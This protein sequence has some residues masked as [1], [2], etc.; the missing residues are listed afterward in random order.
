MSRLINT[1]QPRR[2][3]KTHRNIQDT[4]L[5]KLQGTPTKNVKIYSSES[6]EI[7]TAEASMETGTTRSYKVFETEVGDS[8]A[9]TLSQRGKKEPGKFQAAPEVVQ[10]RLDTRVPASIRYNTSRKSS[11]ES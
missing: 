1:L 6:R 4:K 10:F 3:P 11:L 8:V 2:I 7:T 9:R 5:W